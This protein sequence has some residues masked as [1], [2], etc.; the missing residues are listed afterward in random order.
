MNPDGN[1]VG[2]MT[3][4]LTTDQIRDLPLPE[5]ALGVLG[6]FALNPDR[7]NANTMMGKRTTSLSN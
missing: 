4:A 5:I 3:P 6:N 1:R 2:R 7:V